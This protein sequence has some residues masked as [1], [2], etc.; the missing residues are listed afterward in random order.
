MAN[1]V[2]TVNQLEA[3]SATKVA[4]FEKKLQEMQNNFEDQK[5]TY[6][7]QVET[8][9]TQF[10]QTM[11]EEYDKKFLEVESDLRNKSQLSIGQIED[12]IANRR[13]DLTQKIAEKVV[14]EIWQ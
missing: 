7:N 6:K 1:L 8:D 9:L 3:L 10:K 5:L 11:R 12:E 2:E 4:E 13:E 14:K